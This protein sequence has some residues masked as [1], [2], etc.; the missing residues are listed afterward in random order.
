[1]DLENVHVKK[2]VSTKLHWLHFLTSFTKFWKITKVILMA[3]LNFRVPLSFWKESPSYVI[4][5]GIHKGLPLKMVIHIFLL[6]PLAH[7]CP[8]ITCCS[9]LEIR[10]YHNPWWIQAT[11]SLGNWYQRR[12]QYCGWSKPACRSRVKTFSEGLRWG[13]L[14]RFED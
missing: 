14:V 1:M 10:L 6:S 2:A 5:R 9:L 8:K 11:F 12:V 3:S 7:C 4:S 13:R